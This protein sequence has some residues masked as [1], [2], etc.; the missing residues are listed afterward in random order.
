[1]VA[2][3]TKDFIYQDGKVRL[4]E[5]HPACNLKIRP[6]FWKCDNEQAQ[7]INIYNGGPGQNRALTPILSYF[8]NYNRFEFISVKSA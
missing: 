4:F 2:E 1:M 5:A 7:F 3:G 6:P 8:Q